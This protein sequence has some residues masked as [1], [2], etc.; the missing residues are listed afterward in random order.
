[1]DLP[2]WKELGFKDGENGWIIQDI[3]T[4]DLDKLWQKI[5]KFEYE[6][7][8]SNW[9]KY[10]PKKTKYDPNKKTNIRVKR[11]YYDVELQRNTIRN[12]ELEVSMT[13]ALY[14]EELNLVEIL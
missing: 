8:K 12:E 13:R 9:E 5:P 4:F 14:L 10:L 11:A 6:P 1:M 7:P 3:E 2:I